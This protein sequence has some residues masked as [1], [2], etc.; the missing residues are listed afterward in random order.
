M[1]S[2]S[3]RYDVNRPRPR[4]GHKYT[5]YEVCLGKMMVMCIKQ[6]LSNI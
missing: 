4:Q 3:H 2:R 1:K 6:Q 5:E